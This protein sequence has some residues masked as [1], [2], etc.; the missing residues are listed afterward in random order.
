MHL[1]IILVLAFGATDLWAWLDKTGNVDNSIGAAQLAV[2][3]ADPQFDA[4]Q[5]AVYY[6]K[7]QQARS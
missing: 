5:S 2:V 3:W 7:V 1:S 4:R 6:V